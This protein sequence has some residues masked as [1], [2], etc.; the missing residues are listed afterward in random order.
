[1][2]QGIYK[3]WFRKLFPAERLCHLIRHACCSILLAIATSAFPAR[4]ANNEFIPTFLVL[5]GTGLILSD[6]D[7]NLLGKFDL[8]DTDRFRYDDIHFNG[9]PDTWGAIRSV[10]PDIEIYLYEAG[11]QVPN[12]QDNYSPEY[13]NTISRFDVS[14]NH[15]MGNLNTDNPDLFLLDD[16]GQ[17]IYFLGSTLP[18]KIKHLMDFGSAAFQQYWIE[19]AR[20]D[21]V[22]QPW[23]A[24]GVFVDMTTAT[25]H[26]NNLSALP[27]RYN[28]D[29]IWVPAM[30]SFS[31]AIT[32]VLNQYG[33]KVWCNRGNTR[34]VE[35]YNA[36]LDLDSSLY[37]PDVL[38][39]EGAFVVA[40][41][42]SKDA[43][44]Y[45]EAQ[46]KRQVDLMSKIV[47]SRIAYLS[48]TDLPVDGSGIDNLGKP[49]T[50]WQSV[51]YSLGSF[52]LG[53]NDTLDN[54]YYS[55]VGGDLSV[56][57]IWWF[58]EYERLSLGEAL[59]SYSKVDLPDGTHV[60]MRPFEKGFVYV[61]PTLDDVVNVE[62][63][64]T[65]KQLTH[66]NILQPQSTL[67]DINGFDLPSHNAAFF[68]KAATLTDDRDG[69]GVSDALDCGPD[70]PW[71][72]P[73]AV[74]VKHD[75]IDQDCNGLDLTI[76]I[77]G[78]EYLVRNQKLMVNATS[79][80]NEAA[81]LQLDGYGSMRWIPESSEWRIQVKKLSQAPV[82]VTVSGPEGSETMAVTVN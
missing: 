17:R 35:G 71:I 78:A 6:G 11:P 9:Q 47:N 65:S 52:V 15:S 56:Q 16:S 10:N 29:A 58:D 26:F 64:E 48:H 60:Y 12:F 24:D 34:L 21:I 33:Q 72:Y 30:N 59:R 67:P 51:W 80:L 13:L 27:T 37:P 73:G 57:R 1:V 3:K 32:S 8:I 82:T 62:L 81:D 42:L 41:G 53:K 77:T 38:M 40:W 49:V 55:Y 43:Q 23:V 31:S 18:D 74:E 70:D 22:E 46:W 54:A 39:E 28:R 44:F 7:D 75:G 4:A 68:V 69:D 36:W 61:N 25:L 66:D 5:Y 79:A 2:P 76:D 14:R 20:T 45:P 50:F 19:A 63:P